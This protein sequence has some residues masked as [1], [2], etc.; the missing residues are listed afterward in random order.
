MVNRAV[1]ALLAA[2]VATAALVGGG[3][4]VTGPEEASVPTA[5][6]PTVDSRPLS[7]VDTTDLL[8]ARGDF[9]GRV[10]D[11]LVSDALGAESESESAYGNGERA[12]IGQGEDI[13]HEFGCEWGAA[14]VEAQAWVFAPPVSD[15]QAEALV[16]SARA[17]PGCTPIPSA[18]EFGSPS[19]AL[20]C[21][22]EA[23]Q[24]A[25][26]RGLFGDAWLTCTLGAAATE[27][28]G[29][30]LERADRWCAEVVRAAADS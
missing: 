10:D 18:A 17:G 1:P 3:L 26:Y 24:Q 9:C 22:G 29:E 27:A 25:S 28:R 11:S 14:G 30:L 16:E 12:R 8:V 5:T 6:A 21:A 23:R 15:R 4:A 7:A 2:A 13:A 19:L 20:A